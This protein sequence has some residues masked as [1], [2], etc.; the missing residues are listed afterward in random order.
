MYLLII[1]VAFIYNY[2]YLC[3]GNNKDINSC[4]KYIN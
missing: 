1:I 3:S 4:Y 2:K